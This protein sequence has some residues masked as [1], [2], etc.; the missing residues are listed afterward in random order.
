MIKK[1]KLFLVV[2]SIITSSSIMTYGEVNVKIKDLCYFDGMKE[3]QLFGY[4]IVV[5]LQGTGD[6]NSPLLNSS[7]KNVL[8]TLGLDA[9]KLKTKNSAAVIITVKLPS[10]VRVG[11]KL[12][13]RVSSI[14]DAKS[15]VG[16]V[17]IQSPLRGADGKTY[18]VA[19]GPLSVSKGSGK[20]I[21]TVAVVSNGGIIERG[22]SQQIIKNN[23]MSMVLRNWDFTTAYA[24]QKAVNEKYPNIEIKI[25]ENGK[26]EL[27]LKNNKNVSQIISD[28]ENIEVEASTKAVIIINE[29]DG[30]V[31]S[32]GNVKLS[33]AMV[34]RGSLKI[35]IEDSDKIHYSSAI[36]DG[37]TISDFVETMNAIG[38]KTEDIIAILK[39]LKSSG[40]LH[41]ELV[42]R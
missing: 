23:I 3:N 17:L 21:K 16:G 11:D 39:A 31:V 25:Q 19:Q 9:N 36:K 4:G 22:I 35:E 40:A 38:A 26:I 15:L 6:K 12:D 41:A 18:L 42:V 37:A 29:A 8:K 5:G 1:I 33:K 13:V 20:Q 27:N 28:I 2:I 14:G 32:G 34:S 10:V 30:T 24:I 7:L